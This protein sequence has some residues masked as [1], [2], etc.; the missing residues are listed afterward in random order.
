MS[1]QLGAG[2]E[3]ENHQ[4]TRHCQPLVLDTQPLHEDIEAENNSRDWESSTSLKRVGLLE[5]WTRQIMWEGGWV[6]SL[7]NTFRWIWKKFSIFIT[8]LCVGSIEGEAIRAGV[9][10]SILILIWVFNWLEGA[11]G[12]GRRWVTCQ[13]CKIKTLIEME[14]KEFDSEGSYTNITNL[15]IQVTCSA[16]LDLHRWFH[17]YPPM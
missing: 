3:G 16:I 11:I 9:V 15:H 10:Y 17:F 7:T 6:N 12:N 8:C 14:P 4:S 2:R 1:L 5:S 13:H